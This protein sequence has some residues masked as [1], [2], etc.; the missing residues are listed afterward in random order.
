VIS[1]TNDH[2]VLRPDGRLDHV[3]EPRFAAYRPSVDVFFSSVADLGAAPG[4]AIVLT[5]MG[6]D[7]ARGLKRLKDL[8]WRTIAQ[9]QATSTVWGMPK[10]AFETGAAAQ[11]LPPSAMAEQLN[12]WARRA[13]ASAG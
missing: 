2:L 8:G 11:M 7:G 3:A 13:A 10:T 9:D 1:A 12:Q 5:G 6:K 4:V